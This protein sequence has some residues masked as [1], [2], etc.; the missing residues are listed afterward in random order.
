MCSVHLLER[1]LTLLNDH[2]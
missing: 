2:A 1:K